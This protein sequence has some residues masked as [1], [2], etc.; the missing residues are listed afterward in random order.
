[1][2]NTFGI[3]FYVRNEDS[4][5]GFEVSLDYKNYS[6]NGWAVC[7]DDDSV[8]E[9]MHNGTLNNYSA[10]SSSDLLG[11]AEWIATF[12]VSDDLELAQEM[13]NVIA[14]L[15]LTAKSRDK[16][17]AL[18]EAKRRYASEKGIKFNQV[19]VAR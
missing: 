17:K 7:A 13:A 19:K 14:F 11:A 12:C 6:G 16:K 1:M 4:G 2:Y 18:N 8:G 5:K 10:P 15:E 3:V 9:L